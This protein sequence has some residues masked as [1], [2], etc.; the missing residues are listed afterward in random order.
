MQWEELSHVAIWQMQA[1]WE[2]Q[3]TQDQS[4]HHP[5]QWAFTP[6]PG[7]SYPPARPSGIIS[8]ATSLLP[9]QG[10]YGWPPGPFA[11]MGIRGGPPPGLPA[12]GFPEPPMPLTQPTPISQTVVPWRGILV[13]GDPQLRAL[14]QPLPPLSGV[15]RVS[16]LGR[17]L[18]AYSV[19]EMTWPAPSPGTAGKRCLTPG[20]PARALRTAPRCSAACSAH[21]QAPNGNAGFDKGQS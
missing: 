10:L 6:H 8:P 11:I 21:L 15:G 14:E 9:G 4:P 5:S 13:E 19:G 3:H 20:F 1:G 17:R 12:A 2:A 18:P 7:S 16:L